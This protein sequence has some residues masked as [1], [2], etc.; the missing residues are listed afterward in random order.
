MANTRPGRHY[1][2]KTLPLSVVVV[3][4]LWN[5]V[6]A[7]KCPDSCPIGADGWFVRTIQSISPTRTWVGIAPTLP[8]L[9]LRPRAIPTW[10]VS[11]T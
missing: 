9:I 5:E 11:L 3:D 6:R 2:I 8:T 4:A 10:G 1:L 7:D